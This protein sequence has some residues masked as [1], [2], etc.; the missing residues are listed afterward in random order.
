MSRNVLLMNTGRDLQRWVVES[1]IDSPG[2]MNSQK[3]AYGALRRPIRKEGMSCGS[4]FQPR[5][6]RQD[7]SPTQQGRYFLEGRFGRTGSNE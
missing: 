6:S 7:A 2:L 4:G 5:S 3:E 1:T